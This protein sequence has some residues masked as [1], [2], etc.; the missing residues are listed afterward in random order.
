M[1]FVIKGSKELVYVIVILG[2]L[3][4]Q[5]E[6]LKELNFVM[7]VHQV[8]QDIIAQ[9]VSFFFFFFFLFFFSF[10][11]FFFLSNSFFFF[12]SNFIER[13]CEPITYQ[14]ADFPATQYGNV[15]LGSCITGFVGNPLLECLTSGQ[16]STEIE[17]DP[18]IGKKIF[19]L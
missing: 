12:Q 5:Q 13:V 18:C 7:F 19:N 17:G 9:V 14:N 10:I 16:W 6:K 2:G 4:A 15:A 11:F 8:M 1:V 3:T